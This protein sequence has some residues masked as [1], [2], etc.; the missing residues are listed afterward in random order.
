MQS[1]V[2]LLSIENAPPAT[3]RALEGLQER[4]GELPLCV[5]AAAN[6][7]RTLDG[8]LAMAGSLGWGRI[9]ED[10]A[11]RIAVAIAVVN[12]CSHL[13]EAHRCVLS[14][15]CDV[16]DAEIAL[17]RIGKSADHRYDIALRFAVEIATRRG[18]VSDQ[19]FLEMRQ[20]GFS[21]EEIVEVIA[22]VMLQ[23]F[24][25]YLDLALVP[26]QEN[27]GEAGVVKSISA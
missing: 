19:M 13:E 15:H 26:P 18:R 8:L 11:E 1:R 21:D 22:H 24:S 20:A 17:A 5:R 16:S 2:A 4:F 14:R 25:N 7:P 10:L 3:R 9:P 23:I 12:G 27:G 6:S